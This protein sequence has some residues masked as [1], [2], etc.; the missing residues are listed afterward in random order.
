[1]PLLHEKMKTEALKK[2]LVVIGTY[3]TWFMEWFDL[4]RI[5]SGYK[6]PLEANRKYMLNIMSSC[7][8]VSNG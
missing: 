8:N 7:K 2:F 1:M 5:G 4:F 6:I 3:I